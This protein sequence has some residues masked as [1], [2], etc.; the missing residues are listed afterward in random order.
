MSIHH[1]DFLVE[2]P[3]VEAALQILLA[4]LLDGVSFEVFQYRSK[5]LLLQELPKR[6]RGYS[7]LRASSSYVRDHHRVVVLVDRDRDDCSS[8]KA[9][10]EQMARDAGLPT[11]SS[12]ARGAYFVVNRIAVEELEAWY[13]GDWAAVRAAYP[14]APEGVTSRRGYR[15]PDAIE[16]GTWEAFERILQEGGLFAGGLR[17]IEAARAIAPHMDLERND[18]PSFRCFRDAVR[19]LVTT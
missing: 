16:G 10:L 6:L 11:R 8:L 17:K 3:S 5:D 2:E 4:R 9:R 1:V 12:R 18:S 19:E 13:F 14:A 15:S 7:R